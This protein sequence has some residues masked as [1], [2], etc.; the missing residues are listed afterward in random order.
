MIN[1]FKTQELANIFFFF[2]FHKKFKSFVEHTKKYW[3]IL[4][5]CPDITHKLVQ[6]VSMH[7]SLSNKHSIIYFRIFRKQIEPKML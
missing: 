5:L 4:D 7:E 1:L 3:K 2:F 6:V